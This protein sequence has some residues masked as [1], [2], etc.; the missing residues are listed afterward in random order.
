[1]KRKQ[2]RKFETFEAAKAYLEERGTL[3]FFGKEGY[4][5]EYCVY[6]F[7]LHSGKQYGIYVHDNGLVE[8]YREV[9]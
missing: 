5:Y 3:E 2:K 9:K 7:S 1:M 6:R 8:V 4:N